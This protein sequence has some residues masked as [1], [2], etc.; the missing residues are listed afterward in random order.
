MSYAVLEERGIPA[1]ESKEG[2]I[3][4]VIF[5][6][7]INRWIG[8]AARALLRIVEPANLAAP[9]SRGEVIKSG[10]IHYRAIHSDTSGQ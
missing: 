6:R 3:Q 9:K 2:R 7:Y 5:V 4:A 8:S 1:I 10:A